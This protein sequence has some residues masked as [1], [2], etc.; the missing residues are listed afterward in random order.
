[1]GYATDR[2]TAQLWLQNALDE[3]YQVRGFYFG[4]EPVWN[5]ELQAHEYPDRK[6]VSFGDP[7]HFGLTAEYGF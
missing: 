7:A 1:M 4:L 3:P 2:W 5:E 6:Y